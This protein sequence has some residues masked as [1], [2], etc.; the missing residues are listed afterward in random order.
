MPTLEAQNKSNMES[1]DALFEHATEGIIITNQKGI[2]IKANP[3]SERLF[4]YEKGE[5]LNKTVEELV[6]TRY[7]ETHVHNREGYHKN[8]HARSMG[9]NMD[10]FAKRKDG[11]EFP[12][13]IS[14][15]YYKKEEETF[16]IAFIIDITERKKHE[17]SVKK[18]NRDLEKKVKERTHVLQEAL[19]ELESSKQQLSEALANEKELNDMKSRFVTMASHEFRTPLS[20]ILSSVSLIG[21]Y[22]EADDDEK[23]QKHV[24]RVKSAVTNM[25]LILNDFL[26]AEKL[27]EGKVF[28]KK[29]DADIE[30]IVNEVLTEIHGILKPG[31]K[32]E[33]KH[34]GATHALIDKQMLR[35]ILLNLGSNAIKF[36]PENKAIEVY[37]KVTPKEIIIKVTDHG[38]GIPKEE[39]THLFERFFRAKNVT[40]IQGTGLGLN[41]VTKYL[42]AM[43]GRIEFES[44]LN[45]GTTFTATI[46][47]E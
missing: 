35:N 1:L 5:L 16:V 8:P 41:I 44:E 22:T 37:T 15:S 14:L 29:E 47:N 27:E 30:K 31:Q 45:K 12:V 13:E 9:K 6:P 23:R 21:K 7:K 24:Q 42:E 28:V 19:I 20:T 36:S 26:S 39:Q 25:T 34:E 17:E 33:Y 3:S 46:L 11:S 32:I 2:I 4:G 38:M 18:L 43:N 40:N 10:L